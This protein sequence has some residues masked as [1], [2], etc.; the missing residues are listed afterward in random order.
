M[1]DNQ[2]GITLCIRVAYNWLKSNQLLS[3]LA[4]LTQ[5]SPIFDFTASN[6]SYNGL[7][8]QLWSSKEN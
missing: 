2:V 7:M 1:I 6:L 8:T 4:I 5:T 3:N